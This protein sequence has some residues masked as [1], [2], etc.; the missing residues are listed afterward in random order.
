MRGVILGGVCSLCVLVGDVGITRAEDEEGL[1][2]DE[3]EALESSLMIDEVKVKAPETVELN[4]PPESVR[5]QQVKQDELEGRMARNVADSLRYQSGVRVETNC[6]SCGFTS[7]RLNGL[8]GAYTQILIDGVPSFSG[9]AGVYGLEQLPVELIESI[10]IVKGG[11]SALY[12]PSAIAGV[13]QINTRRPVASFARAQLSYDALSLSAPWVRASVD[14]AYVSDDKRFATH[15][16][17]VSSE[18]APLDLNDDALTEITR[19]E[20]LAAGV[21]TSFLLFD[22]AQLDLKLHALTEGRRGGGQLEL[23]PHDASVAES[24]DTRRRH[25]ELRWRHELSPQLDYA[26]SYVY[27]KTAR[28]SYYGGGGDVSTQP[29]AGDASTWTPEQRQDY[30]ERLAQRE[31]ALG[32]YG[33]TD[34]PL[35][36]ADARLRWHVGEARSQTWTVAAQLQ[37]D[38]VEDKYLSYQREVDATYTNLGAV[39]E[40]QWSFA[41][42]G[43][44]TMGVRLDKHSELSAPVLSPRGS[45]RFLL[46]DVLSLRTALSSGFR[47]QQV[48]DE[49]LHIETVGGSARLISNSDELRPE[50]AWGLTQQISVDWDA[51]AQWVLK[52]GVTGYVNLLRDAFVV[53]ER[54]DPSTPEEEAV[55]TNRG[56]TRTVGG[57]LEASVKWRGILGLRLGWTLEDARNEQPDE[58]FGRVRILR[59]PRQYGYAEAVFADHG[60]ELRSAL[61]VTGPML[62]PLYD[63]QGDP[64]VVNTTPWFFDLSMNV[65]YQHLVSQSYLLTPLLGVRNVF[66]SYQRDLQRGP[67]RDAGYVYGPGQPR[68]IYLGLEVGL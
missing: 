22:G 53:N 68:S 44:S 45:A 48:F 14:G 34:N 2:E 64:S 6:Q 12:G 36:L 4:A 67:Q 25:L 59:T 3:L 31:A 23:P 47:A 15:V 52:L 39:L 28:R 60:F 13:I 62:A 32:A 17:A 7:V 57:E 58:D 56:Q 55:R 30:E 51:S 27:A 65:R 9:L 19:L 66:N 43:F 33:L 26:L 49:D 54:D 37:S 42:W 46:G 18:R 50:R 20:Q 11:G 8:E 24:I 63:G 35:H 16:F 5:R 10:D 1:G 41:A 38:G 40:Q 61:E 21:T 29:P